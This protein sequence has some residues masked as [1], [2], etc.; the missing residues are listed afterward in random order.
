M[1]MDAAIKSRFMYFRGPNRNRTP[2]GSGSDRMCLTQLW[3][4]VD[5]QRRFFEWES[6][7]WKTT[8][9]HFDIRKHVIQ[10]VLNNLTE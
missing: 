10:F 8:F 3:A 1:Q 2:I 5:G 6:I 4:A 7:L 9:V